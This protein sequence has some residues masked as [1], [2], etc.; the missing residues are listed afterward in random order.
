MFISFSLV[1]LSIIHCVNLEYNE[2][3]YLKA[4]WINFVILTVFAQIEYGM[5]F[6]N[7]YFYKILFTW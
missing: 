7:A 4:L 5:Y 3:Y 6:L 2:G 1:I